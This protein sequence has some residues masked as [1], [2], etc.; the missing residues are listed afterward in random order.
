LKLGVWT[1]WPEERVRQ[2]VGPDKLGD[3]IRLDMNPTFPVDVAARVTAV[4]FRDNSIDCISSNS[5]FEHVPYSHDIL[6][7]LPRA[8]GRR[9][10][11]K[12]VPFHLIEHGCPKDYLQISPPTP[13]QTRYGI[14]A[15]SFWLRD[16]ART[17]C[18]VQQMPVSGPHGVS[19]N[20]TDDHV[21]GECPPRLFA[22][23]YLNFLSKSCLE[24][25]Y[26]QIPTKSPT[27]SE[28]MSPGDTR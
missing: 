17:R 20:E 11:R 15:N 26:L 1:A 22:M 4:R 19:T 5:L 28:M 8:P 6:R 2:H 18:V 7:E 9:A 16:R 21:D 24:A 25:N 3:I 23:R 10:L 13:Q 27:D 12:T 14:S